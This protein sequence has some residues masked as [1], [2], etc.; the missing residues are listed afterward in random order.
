[1]VN[2][3]ARE[4]LGAYLRAKKAEFLEIKRTKDEFKA[5][6]GFDKIVTPVLRPKTAGLSLAEIEAEKRRKQRMVIRAL[7]KSPEQIKVLDE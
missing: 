6:P 1:M 3:D 4:D 2:F 7:Y 5:E